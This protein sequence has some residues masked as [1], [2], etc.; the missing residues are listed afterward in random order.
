MFKV[1]LELDGL[2]AVETRKVAM[3]GEIMEAV[4]NSEDFERFVKNF[5]YSYQQCT[6]RLW[7][8]KC[9]TVVAKGFVDNLGLNNE[10]VYQKLML[11]KE[12]LGEEGEGNDADVHLRVDRRFTRGVVGYTNPGTKWQYVYKWVLNDWSVNDLAGNLAHEHCHKIGFDHSYYN[13]AL[14]PYSVPYAV[15]QFVSTYKI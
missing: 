14:R 5:S 10:Q 7:W 11:G 13:N 3:A 1:H 2:D 15:G 12:T 9:T 4:Y 6:G 8:K